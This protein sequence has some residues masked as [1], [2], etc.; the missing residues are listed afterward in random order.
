MYELFDLC[1]TRL[2]PLLKLFQIAH[3]LN[4]TLQLLDL[5][6]LAQHAFS[7]ACTER[8]A[9]VK[10][11]DLPLLILFSCVEFLAFLGSRFF[12]IYNR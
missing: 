11:L 1:I 5:S 4:L 2:K 7:F 8:H 6:V 10:L 9:L 12:V 3:V